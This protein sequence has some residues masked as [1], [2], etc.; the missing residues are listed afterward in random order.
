[1][2]EKKLRKIIALAVFVGA[3]M[4]L[5]DITYGTTILLGGLAAFLLL[6]LIKLLAKRR[7]TWTTLH[8]VQLIL[9]LIAMASL[10]L[11]YYEYPY[12]RVVFVIAF[13]AESLVSAKIMLNEKFGSTN[14]N[15][16]FSIVKRFLLAQRQGTGRL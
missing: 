15:N 12:G 7:Y 4:A 1:M 14:V 3:I 8:Y 10:A 11:R 9:I 13:L 2:T 6:K 16:F 5:F